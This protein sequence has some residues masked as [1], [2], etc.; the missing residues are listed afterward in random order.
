M[1]RL[2][3]ASPERRE[4]IENEIATIYWYPIYAYARSMRYK[5]HEAEDLTQSFL[6]MLFHRE[7]FDTVDPS[8][9][10]LRTF[11]CVSMKN[12]VADHVRQKHTL[13]RG[14]GYTTISIDVVDAEERIAM[15]NYQS[16]STQE[17]FD[18]RAMMSV[19]ED[20][21]A[22]MEA[23]YEKRNDLETFRA[24]VD[25]IPWGTQARVRA[26]LAGQL[27][28]ERSTLETRI[29]RARKRFKDL[30]IHHIQN[31]LDPGQSVEEEIRYYQWLASCRA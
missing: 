2:K 5:T 4:G 31:T 16:L 10:K 6:S 21:M 15:E 18:K 13:K 17:A 7:L 28:I 22:K 30:L 24:I 11:L 25:H 26:D 19:F 1:A 14:G 27:S 29:Y 8:K 12:F 3:S 20:I 9:G 23:E